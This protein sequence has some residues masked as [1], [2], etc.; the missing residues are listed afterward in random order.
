VNCSGVLAFYR[1]PYVL[2]VPVQSVEQQINNYVATMS[3]ANNVVINPVSSV[4]LEQAILTADRSV[5]LVEQGL[6]PAQT[7]AQDA[8]NMGLS[9]AAVASEFAQT[10]GVRETSATGVVQIDVT[11]IIQIGLPLV[12]QAPIA[13]QDLLDEEEDE[14]EEPTE[15][16]TAED[17]AAPLAA[18]SDDATVGPLS[19]LLN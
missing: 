12:Q 5:A 17:D 16:A 10:F 8:V 15:E 6:E 7:I 3:N 13:P 2:Q 18:I 11:D 19:L 1:L 9:D 4:R 14:T